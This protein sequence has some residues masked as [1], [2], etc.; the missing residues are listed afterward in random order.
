MTLQLRDWSWVVVNFSG[1][2]DSSAC[3]L[4]VLQEAEQ[5]GFPRDRII[6]S[7]QCLGRQEWKGTLQLV[8]DVAEKYKLPL[9][10]TA[11]RNKDQK[12][13]SLL[14]YVRKRG[15]WPDSSNRYCTSEFKRGPGNRVLTELRRQ[16]PG[17]ILQCF[18][19]RAEE[20]AARCKRSELSYNNR[21]STAAWGVWD[22][23]P[24]HKMRE[25][26]VWSAVRASGMPVHPAYALGM[27]R[28]SCVF[29]IFAPQA[30]LV[31]AGQHN[32]ELLEEYAKVEQEIGHDFQHHKP[33]SRILDVVRGHSR[34]ERDDTDDKWNM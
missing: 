26:E 30:Q 27:R 5:C 15:K 31:L 21:A 10:V 24:I 28:L 16:H 25:E 33:I 22:W 29:C 13:L 9:H 8:K 3:L 1:G 4:Q 2:K 32:T 7:H 23:L 19:F 6:L 20:S 34:L 17:H 14:E 11:Y 12:P 18:G